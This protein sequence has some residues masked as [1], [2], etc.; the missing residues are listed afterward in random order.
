MGEGSSGHRLDWGRRG[1][2]KHARRVVLAFTEAMLSDED[3]A[4]NLVPGRPEAC[5]RAV[6]AFDDS[7]GRSSPDLRRG[8]TA[9]AFFMEWLPLLVIGAPSRMTRLPLARRLAYLEGLEASRIGWLSMLLVAFKV[10]LGIPAFEEGEELSLTGI[11]RPSTIARRK[12]PVVATRAEK[13]EIGAE[14]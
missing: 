4:G 8:F 3:D 6:A 1:L 10:P 13:A 14:A 9:L 11:D 5:A 12:L 7:L 2:S